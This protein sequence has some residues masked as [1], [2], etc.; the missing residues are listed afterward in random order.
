MIGRVVVH[1]TQNRIEVSFGEYVGD[2]FF[3]KET[4]FYGKEDELKLKEDTNEEVSKLVSFI[5]KAPVYT[6][7]K[8]TMR[9]ARLALL[10][11]G[12]LESVDALIKTDPDRISWEYSA[13]VYR[14]S[15]L[16]VKL[17]TELNLTDE[18]LD[19]LFFEASKL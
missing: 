17:K 11:A 14:N 9:Q 4:K 1:I 15:D 8:V 6:V 13:E 5:N 10:N 18:Q 3:V 2:V 19:E 16:V 12:L 7:S